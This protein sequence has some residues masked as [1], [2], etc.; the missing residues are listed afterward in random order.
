MRWPENLPQIIPQVQAWRQEWGILAPE[1][2]SKDEGSY[3]IDFLLGSWVSFSQPNMAPHRI[4]NTEITDEQFQS[5][6]EQTCQ[7]FGQARE[8]SFVEYELDDCFFRVNPQGTYRTVREDTQWLGSLPYGGVR[9]YQTWSVRNERFPMTLDYDHRTDTIVHEWKPDTSGMSIWMKRCLEET[10]HEWKTVGVTWTGN[11]ASRRDAGS[12]WQQWMERVS[13]E[14]RLKY[15]LLPFWGVDH[16][17]ARNG[18]LAIS[19]S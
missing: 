7:L 18:Q 10:G 9:V 8:L 17:T 11:A 5:I 15:E 16:P 19:Y 13:E 2:T 12:K 4:L 1:D 6:M 14:E 3:N